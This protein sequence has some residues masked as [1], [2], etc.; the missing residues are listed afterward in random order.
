MREPPVVNLG[1]Q[2]GDIDTGDIAGGNIYYGLPANEVVQLLAYAIDKEST[3]R[4]L[5]GAVREV[6]QAENDAAMARL[7]HELWLMRWALT[8]AAVAI[9]VILAVR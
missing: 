2:A 5:D 7:Y 3:F 1:G 6:R 9:V 4:R 8:L